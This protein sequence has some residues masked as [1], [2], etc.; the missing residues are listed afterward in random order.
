MYFLSLGEKT[1]GS[2]D[3]QSPGGDGQ[4]F[5]TMQLSAAH[6]ARLDE[7][8]LYNQGFWAVQTVFMPR[9]VEGAKAAGGAENIL[10]VAAASATAVAVK[11]ESGGSSKK[12]RK[13]RHRTEKRNEK[14]R[15]TRAAKRAEP[16]ASGEAKQTKQGAPPAKAQVA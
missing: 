11:G 8:M 13:Q 6:T 14:N 3:A 16:T 2:G 12:P 5:N 1:D 7:E 10:W 4:F 9:L 15:A